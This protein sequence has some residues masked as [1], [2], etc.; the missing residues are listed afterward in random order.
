MNPSPSPLPPTDHLGR[1]QKVLGIVAFLV[2][3]GLGLIRL[4]MWVAEATAPPVTVS[5]PADLA[6]EVGACRELAR[7]LRAGPLPRK[8]TP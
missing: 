8:D 1:A 7:L 2:G 4:G 6:A 5:L 3:G